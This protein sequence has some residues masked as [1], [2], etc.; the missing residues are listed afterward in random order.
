MDDIEVTRVNG[1]HYVPQKF[2]R[3]QY[4]HGYYKNH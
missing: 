4:Y 1:K 3:I 2:V